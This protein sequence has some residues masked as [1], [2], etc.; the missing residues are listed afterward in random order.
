MLKVKIPT[1]TGI[2]ALTQNEWFKAERLNRDYYLYAVMN[3][4]SNNP[5][6]FTDNDPV[7]NLEAVER[8]EVV[9]FMISAEGLLSK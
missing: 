6:L 7:A 3:P 2:V 8:F 9:R 1:R 4:G 5:L